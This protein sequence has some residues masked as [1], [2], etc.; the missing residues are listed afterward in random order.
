MRMLMGNIDA[1]ALDRVMEARDAA[2][3][4]LR[5]IPSRRSVR[6]S[7]PTMFC[8]STVW[9]LRRWGRI[10]VAG[11]LTEVC[12]ARLWRSVWDDK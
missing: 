6:Y 9:A 7:V 1:R 5:R 2:L 3:N 4:N 12:A 8:A 10:C 11:T